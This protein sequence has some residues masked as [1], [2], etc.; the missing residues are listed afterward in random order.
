MY[1]QSEY[2]EL[3]T[4]KKKIRGTKTLKYTSVLSKSKSR[5]ERIDGELWRG[6]ITTLPLLYNNIE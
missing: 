4:I 1:I 3:Y 2:K 5:K 6:L